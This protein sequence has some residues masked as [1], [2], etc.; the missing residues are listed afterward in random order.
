MFWLIQ[1]NQ[2]LSD[3]YQFN[4]LLQ[5]PFHPVAGVLALRGSGADHHLRED[6]PLLPVQLITAKI[7]CSFHPQIEMCL[8]ADKFIFACILCLFVKI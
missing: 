1:Q 5:V 6:V 3:L 7:I 4:L 2:K 8:L